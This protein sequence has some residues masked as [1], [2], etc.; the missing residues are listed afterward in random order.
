MKFTKIC[1]GE[2]SSPKTQ[3]QRRADPA[4]TPFE[5]GYRMP[6]EWEPHEATWLSWPH[7]EE[8][9]PGK[10]QVIEEVYLQMMGALT[11]SEKVYLLVNDEKEREHVAKKARTRGVKNQNLI[12]F[13]V[14]TVDAW[15]RDYGPNFIA[16]D[17]NGK[18][19][20]AWV[21][22]RFNAWGA[23][24]ESLMLDDRVGDQLA[25]RLGMTVHRPEL[26]LEGGSIDTNG[27]GTCLTT[28]QCLLNPNRNQGVS[29]S[30]IAKALRDYLGFTHL[31]WLGD[32]IEG[33]DTDGHIDD[34]ARFVSPT[35]VAAAIEENQNDKNFHPLQENLKTLREAKD[36]N[37]KKLNTVT[38][39]MPDR[40]DVSWGRLP[41]SYMNFYIGNGVVLVPIFGH[42]QDEKAL[43][44]LKDLFP[45][46]RIVGIRCEDLVM[47]M[48]AIH[49]VSHE[50]PAGVK[51]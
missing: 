25:S 19:E 12:F 30:E 48:G 27:L 15:I 5:L 41:A 16:R 14:P 11:E 49:C 1:K 42:R 20:V 37:G 47:G 34:I 17:S 3:I 9:W 31:I 40:I 39:P 46:H 44:I 24:Y 36:Q 21:K 22:W 28:E 7:N 35:T 32:G 18:K 23:K 10:A 45:A 38:L 51:S 26:I 13:E 4:S 6:A 2:V 8:T 33:D 43:E 50:M 29:K